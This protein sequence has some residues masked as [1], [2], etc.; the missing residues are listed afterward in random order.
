MKKSWIRRWVAGERR[1]NMK[2]R[3]ERTR[4]MEQSKIR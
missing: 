3:R 2:K 4:E 1:R